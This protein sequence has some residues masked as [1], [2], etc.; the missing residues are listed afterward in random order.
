MPSDNAAWAIAIEPSNEHMCEDRERGNAHGLPDRQRKE[1]SMSAHRKIP[2]TPK[3]KTPRSSGSGQLTPE[4][5][6][7]LREGIR[8]ARAMRERL[9]ALTGSDRLEYVRSLFEEH[10]LVFC[11]CGSDGGGILAKGRVDPETI[12]DHV[13]IP[14]RSEEEAYEFY[15]RFGDG[16]AK[17]SHA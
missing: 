5:R 7:L 4:F 16:R 6:T 2:K 11:D 14:C 1:S 13:V 17:A 3:Q 9:E 10:D 8:I 15:H 12:E